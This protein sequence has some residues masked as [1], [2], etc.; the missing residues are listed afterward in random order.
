IV[1]GLTAC[2]SEAKRAADS[3]R[4]DSIARVRQDSINRAQPGYVIDSVHPPEENLRRFRAAVGGEPATKFTGGSSSRD[5]LV[6]RF[7]VAISARDPIAFAGMVMSGRE[8]AYLYYP[9]SPNSHPPLYQPPAEEWSLIQIPSRAGMDDLLR[10][11]G[12]QTV[13]YGG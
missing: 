13:R 2:S 12:G 3:A 6:R 5:S 8:F 9:V 4:A 10:K 1:F 7:L 11:F